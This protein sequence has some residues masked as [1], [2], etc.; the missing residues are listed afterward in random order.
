MRTDCGESGCRRGLL[1]A[2]STLSWLQAGGSDVGEQKPADSGEE[3]RLAGE[4]PGGRQLLKGPGATSF[5]EEQS[6]CP[7]VSGEGPRPG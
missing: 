4:T 5:R 2:E 1:L 7:R 6:S 3:G